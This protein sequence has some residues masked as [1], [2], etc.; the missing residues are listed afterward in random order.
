MHTEHNTYSLA[1]YITDHLD[2]PERD[3]VR[4]HLQKCSECQ[5]QVDELKAAFDT[6]QQTHE[7]VPNSA[8]Y[9]TILP[10]VQARLRDRHDS[11]WNYR[12]ILSRLIVPLAASALLLFLVI[13]IPTDVV[14]EHEQTSILF[15]VVK[16][17]SPEEVVQAVT[18]ESAGSN[19]LLNPDVMSEGVAEHFKGD[20]F[21]REALVQ[22]IESGE[23]GDMDIDGVLSG[24]N[25]EQTEQLV[26]GLTEREML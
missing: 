6:L 8:Y 14:P 1:D 19:V 23:I 26:S 9:S 3:Q 20:H 4:L 10:R 22:Q 5:Q 12:M 18:N 17:Y 25:R 2:K 21:I 7:V 13:K 16:D 24:L 15:Q 11:S